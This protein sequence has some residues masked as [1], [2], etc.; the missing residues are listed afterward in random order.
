MRRLL[1]GEK[2]LVEADSG[3][4]DRDQ[5]R[6]PG[7]DEKDTEVPG[8]GWDD[9]VTE[10][11]GEG[12]DPRYQREELFAQ[13]FGLRILEPEESLGRIIIRRLLRQGSVDRLV[14]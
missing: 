2:Y 3:A 1:P 14:P 7:D 4:N 6:E 8:A 10:G 5:E 9:L 12:Q 11:H 13:V